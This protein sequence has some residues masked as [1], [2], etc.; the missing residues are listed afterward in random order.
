MGVLALIG[1]WEEG[2]YWDD[3]DE[4]MRSDDWM[5]GMK[6]RQLKSNST[7]CFSTPD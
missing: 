2:R 6:Q 7:L 3:R 4:F 1:R 5:T